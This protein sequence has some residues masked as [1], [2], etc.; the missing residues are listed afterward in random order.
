MG[1]RELVYMRLVH[2]H[3]LHFVFCSPYESI[4]RTISLTTASASASALASALALQNVKG[5]D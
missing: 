2:L 4:Y 5:L 3:A 1:K